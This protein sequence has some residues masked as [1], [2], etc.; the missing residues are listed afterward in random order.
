MY[1]VKGKTWWAGI[2]TLT[3]SNTSN[4]NIK[5]AGKSKQ[6]YSSCYPLLAVLI[7]LHFF[8]LINLFLINDACSKLCNIWLLF[9]ENN[10]RSYHYTGA[11][12][13]M[14]SVA[15]I[16]QDRMINDNW[17]RKIK[18]KTSHTCRF[19]LPTSLVQYISNWWKAFEHPSPPSFFNIHRVIIF[20]NASRSVN[21]QLIMQGYI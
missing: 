19:F 16:T 18:N 2:G 5:C 10:S 20:P 7:Y 3:H 1:P 15:V 14:E 13:W 8:I 12:R 11:L 17:K 4:V 21:F 6:L 9:F